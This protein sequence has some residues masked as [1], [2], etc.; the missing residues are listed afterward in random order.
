MYYDIEIDPATT[1]PTKMRV[2]LLTGQKGATITKKN[3]IIGGDHVAFYFDYELSGFDSTKMDIPAPAK[4][5]LA[6]MR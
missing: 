1:L 5:L 3:R 6:K 2:L 4:K